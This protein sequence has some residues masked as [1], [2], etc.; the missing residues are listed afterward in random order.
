MELDS[1]QIKVY[2]RWG[3]QVFSANL[4]EFEWDGNSK[5]MQQ[6]VGN[7][8]YFIRYKASG[9]TQEHLLKGDLLL[10]R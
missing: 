9:E 4:P 8:M 10:I 2:N 3:E 1:Y 5:G 7:F 6:Q